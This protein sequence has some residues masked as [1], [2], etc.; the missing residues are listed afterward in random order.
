MPTNAAPCSRTT[1][2]TATPWADD[3]SGFTSTAAFGTPQPQDQHDVVFSAEPGNPH[4]QGAL[5]HCPTLS[6]GT[7]RSSRRFARVQGTSLAVPTGGLLQ[8]REIAG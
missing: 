3:N 5:V 6:A 8:V 4:G 2:C 7:G 1:A